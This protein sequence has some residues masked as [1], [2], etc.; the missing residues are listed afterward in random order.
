MT[1]LELGVDV[2]RLPSALKKMEELNRAR[3]A[4]TNF[5]GYPTLNERERFVRA[6][7]KMRPDPRKSRS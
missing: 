1:L 4:K 5:T 6:L 7:M 2:S 3:G